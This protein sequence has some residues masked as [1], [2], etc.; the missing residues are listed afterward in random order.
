MMNAGDFNWIVASYSKCNEYT[1][2]N[3][4]EEAGNFEQEAEYESQHICLLFPGCW[5]S[6]QIRHLDVANNPK[7][8][9]TIILGDQ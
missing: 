5:L 2:H 4:S 1:F 9:L 3:R 7:T 8:D 6:R